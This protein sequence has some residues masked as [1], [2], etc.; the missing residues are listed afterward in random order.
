M[1]RLYISAPRVAKNSFVSGLL[2]Q[3][4]PATGGEWPREGSP[5]G[6]TPWVTEV[7]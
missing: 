1:L 3:I 6:K 2:K 4:L 5:A 7:G